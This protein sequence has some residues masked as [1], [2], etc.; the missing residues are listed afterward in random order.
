MAWP[1]SRSTPNEPVRTPLYDTGISLPLQTE[2][3]HIVS[4]NHDTSADNDD[5]NDGNN[6]ASILQVKLQEQVPFEQTTESLLQNHARQQQGTSS[7]QASIHLIKGYIGPGCLSLPWAFSQ[8]GVIW[9]IVA[10]VVLSIWTSFLAWTIVRA[11]LPGETY[12]D[13][14]TRVYGPSFGSY[15]RKC[16]CFQQLGI[17]TV[18]VTFVGENLL[19]IQAG[20]TAAFTM[21]CVL[22]ILLGITWYATPSLQ[23]MAPMTAAATVLW[24]IAL[25]LMAA[26]IFDEWSQ[27]PRDHDTKIITADATPNGPLMALC[28][29]LY[30]FEG[31]CLILPIESSMTQ[32]KHFPIVFFSSMTIVTLVFCVIGSIC[33]LCYGP[34]ITNGSITAYMLEQPHTSSNGLVLLFANTAISMSVLL[35]YPLQLFP[36]LEQMR[37]CPK[38]IG[39]VL[40]TYSIAMA[41][42]NVQSL[43]SLTGALTGSSTALIVP[44]CLILMS[45]QRQSDVNTNVMILYMIMVAIGSAFLVIG[46]FVSIVTMFRLPFV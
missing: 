28:A 12:P 5:G 24:G 41:V 34:V 33:V 30:S 27:R 6:Y 14:V 42:P 25:L 10:C 40:L 3:V 17:C 19:A 22:P 18:F 36:C 39:L 4:H 38:Q 13:I 16:I 11:K 9:G 21:T 15:L 43:I 46:T 45:Q 23:I 29:I 32:P 35:T 2:L 26:V 44:P 1:S 8:L 7:I 31:I 20:H 37:G